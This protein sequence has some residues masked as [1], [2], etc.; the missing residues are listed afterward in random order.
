MLQLGVLELGALDTRVMWA[1]W[2]DLKCCLAARYSRLDDSTMPRLLMLLPACRA[3]VAM[4]TCIRA[5]AV[6]L[7]TLHRLA[8]C[9]H[10]FVE[11]RTWYGEMLS[12]TDQMAYMFV[13][14]WHLRGLTIAELCQMTTVMRCAILIFYNSWKAFFE[15]VINRPYW[16]KLLKKRLLE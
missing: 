7:H 3:S 15:S 4:A 9:V 14:V 11:R 13:V 1:G 6:R 8:V 5:S 10:V 2:S 12:P 16:R